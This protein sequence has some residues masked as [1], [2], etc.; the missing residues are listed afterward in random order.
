MPITYAGVL[1]GD[2]YNANITTTGAGTANSASFD[3]RNLAGTALLGINDRASGTAAATIAVTHS[4][5][6]STFV[7]IPTAAL[8]IP[9]TGVA[10]TFTA[11]STSASEQFLGLH[12][13]LLKRYVRVQF[14]GTD[15]AHNVA[16]VL[17]GGKQYSGG[18]G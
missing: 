11:L 12:F 2:I 7:A 9:S 4:E 6:N 15:I 3:L 18:V 8:F 5:D 17:V 10:S 14:T 16:I 1:S 13:Q